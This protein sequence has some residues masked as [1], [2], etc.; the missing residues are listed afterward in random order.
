MFSLAIFRCSIRSHCPVKYRDIKCPQQQQQRYFLKRFGFVKDSG[1]ES[2]RPATADGKEAEGE[3]T[4]G[5]GEKQNLL[6]SGRVVFEDDPQPAMRIQRNRSGLR[7][8]HRNLLHEQLPY[9]EPQS[10]IHLTEKYQRKQFGRYG[11]ASGIDPRICFNTPERQMEEDR[12]RHNYQEPETIQEMI[13]KSNDAQQAREE[14]KRK[15]EEDLLKKMA[16]LEKWKNEL[17][18]KMAKKESEALA[19]KE[20]KERLVEEVRRQFGFKI[21]PRDERFREAL[22]LKEKEEKKR[23]KEERRKAKDIKTM[24]KIIAINTPPAAASDTNNKP[25]PQQ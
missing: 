4:T 14:M 15:R 10:W 2:G 9:S 5:D 7:D 16:S 8:A 1:D 6:D 18:M 25:E 21:D 22:E 19:A 24:A 12:Y 13:R 17:E 11:M 23:L 20:R 3:A